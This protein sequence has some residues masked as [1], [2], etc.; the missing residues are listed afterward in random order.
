MV[1]VNFLKGAILVPEV[2]SNAIGTELLPIELSAILRLVLIIYALFLLIQIKRILLA[3]F[4]GA[5][6]VLTLPS[7]ATEACFDPIFAKLALVHR[8]LHE[9]LSCRHS[10]LIGLSN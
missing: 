5:M 3:E 2:T 4:I 7:V 1:P 10:A 8:P 6:R 9:R